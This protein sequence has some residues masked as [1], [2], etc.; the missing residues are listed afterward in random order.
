MILGYR[1]QRRLDAD[2]RRSALYR[3]AGAIAGLLLSGLFLRI[4]G[5]NP[6]T[7]LADS[8]EAVFA[9]VRDLLGN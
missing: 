8:F 4:T 5:R 3:I 6:F 7:I 2:A 9:D 1:L